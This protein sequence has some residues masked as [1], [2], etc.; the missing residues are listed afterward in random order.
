MEEATNQPDAVAG[1]AIQCLHGLTRLGAGV[2]RV[3]LAGEAIGKVAQQEYCISLLQAHRLRLTVD[4]QPA[5]SLHHQ[6]EAGAAHTL[7]AGVPATAIAADMKQAGI[8]LQA[9]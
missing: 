9:F 5:I 2:D 6:V 1:F 7:G 4:V 3:L 8:E